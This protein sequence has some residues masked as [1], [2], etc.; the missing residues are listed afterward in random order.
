MLKQKVE[1]LDCL[2]PGEK[3]TDIVTRF[4]C[5]SKAKKNELKYLCYKISKKIQNRE[6]NFIDV[7][8]AVLQWATQMHAKNAVVVW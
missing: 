4:K 3:V 7:D 2:K 6:G 8:D 1:I 5:V